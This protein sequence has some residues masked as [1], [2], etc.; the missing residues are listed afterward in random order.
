MQDAHQRLIER[1][2]RIEQGFGPIH[3]RLDR[4]EAA[5]TEPAEGL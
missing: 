1:I 5:V 3:E 4:L 2:Q